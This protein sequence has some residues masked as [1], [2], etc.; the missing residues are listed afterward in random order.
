[1]CVN[2]SFI[3]LVRMLAAGLLAAAKKWCP[4]LGVFQVVKG[5]R[6]PRG[7]EPRV[8]S[9]A[10]VLSRCSWATSKGLPAL[11]PR[12]N[13]GGGGLQARWGWVR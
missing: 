6:R 10:E 8:S 12:G 13:D 4:S 9:G 2:P 5:H 7:H 1:M 11:L 3:V